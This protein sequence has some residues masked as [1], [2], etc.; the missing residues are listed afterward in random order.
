MQKEKKLHQ[1]LYTIAFVD[2]SIKNILDSTTLFERPEWLDTVF[3]LVFF[4]CIGWK[5]LLQTFTKP[6]LLGTILLGIPFAFVSFRMKYFFLL[7]TYCG[8][9]SLQYVNLRNVLKYTSITKLLLILMHVVFHVVTAI[10]TPE[11]IEYVYRNGVQ[12]QF[13]YLG[14]PNTFSMYVGWAFLEFTYVYYRQIKI[15][16]L[17]VIWIINFVAYQFTDSNTSLIVATLC[18]IG[19]LA[20]RA[21]PRLMAR[22]LTPLARYAYAFCA[23]FF[24]VITIWFTKMPAALKQI[25][26]KLNEFFTGRLLFGSFTY[27]HYGIAWLGNPNIYLKDTT[28]FEGFWVDTL[29]YDNSYIY[30]LVRYGAIFLP[31]FAIAFMM[32]EKD[33]KP[34]INRNVEKI[35][36]LAYTFFAIMENYAI[37]AVLC[38]PILFIGQRLFIIYEEKKEQKRAIKETAVGEKNYEREVECNHSCI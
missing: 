8:V 20:E 36:V 10:F 37:N 7:F 26:L 29:I 15:A 2:L 12:R 14:H 9:I 19:F 27:E 18:L 1:Q 34:D 35:L 4:G 11:Q 38:F 16:H 30:L 6:M 17:I 28:Y 21:K 5:L 24:T 22:I 33:K 13:F 3:L 23:V 31:I 32:A 25:Y